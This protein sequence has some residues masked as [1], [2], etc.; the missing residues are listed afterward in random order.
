MYSLENETSVQVFLCKSRG[1]IDGTDPKPYMQ[2]QD[3]IN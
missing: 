1:P 3:M 2:L